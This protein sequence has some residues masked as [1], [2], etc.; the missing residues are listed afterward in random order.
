MKIGFVLDD[1]LDSNDGVQQYVRTLGA[2]LTQQGHIVDHLAGETKQT[3]EHIHS[4]SKNVT[5][6]FNGNRFT[7][8]FSASSQKIRVLEARVFFG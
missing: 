6:K 5:M 2:W 4:L 8:P 7:I 1:G 3:A